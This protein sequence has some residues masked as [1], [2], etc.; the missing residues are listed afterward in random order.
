MSKRIGLYRISKKLYRGEEF[1]LDV[2]YSGD[3]CT[4]PDAEYNKKERVEETAMN[5][6][7]FVEWLN[8]WQEVEL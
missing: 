3:F 6:P 2:H 7:S 8:D 1:Y 4:S 5:D